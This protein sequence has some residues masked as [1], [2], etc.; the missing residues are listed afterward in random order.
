MGERMSLRMHKSE[1]PERMGRTVKKGET[2]E[3]GGWE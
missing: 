1:R 2:V 3:G